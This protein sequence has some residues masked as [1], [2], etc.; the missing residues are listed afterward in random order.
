MWSWWDH[1]KITVLE[2]D[3][4]ITD[5]VEN[6][7][8]AIEIISPTEGTVLNGTI[9]IIWSASDE[10]GDPLTVRIELIVLPGTA[11]FTLFDGQDPVDQKLSINTTGYNNGTYELRVTVND[12]FNITVV[13]VLNLE[14][15]NEV[16]VITD[17]DDDDDDVV[18]DD[19]TDDD[20]VSDPDDDNGGGRR[21]ST[22]M[23]IGIVVVLLIAGLLIFG[24]ARWLYERKDDDDVYSFDEE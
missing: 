4:N 6:T 10:D 1:V 5:P 18:D 3:V 17:D 24:I 11:S 2:E 9:D 14:I 8:P 23:I 13:H 12:G 16:P 19:T 20:E 15:R 21:I 22:Q 7:P